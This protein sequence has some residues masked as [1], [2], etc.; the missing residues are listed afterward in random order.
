MSIKRGGGPKTLPATLTITGQGSTDK[1]DVVYH[2][3]KTSEVQGRLAGGC[4]LG[5]LVVYL[6]D[7]WDTDFELTEEGV[8]DAEDEYPGFVDIIIA[9]YHAARHK[10]LE[11]N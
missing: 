9:G 4:S 5:A 7:S 11:K 6:V 2:N 10:A 3:R 1:L 8:R